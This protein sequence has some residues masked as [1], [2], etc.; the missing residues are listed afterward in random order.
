MHH[1]FLL[2]VIFFVT[3]FICDITVNIDDLCCRINQYLVEFILGKYIF[4][5][6]SE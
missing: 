4:F 3:L 6:L 5:E 1:I 2:H